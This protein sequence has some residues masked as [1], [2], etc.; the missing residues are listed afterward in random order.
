MDGQ[1]DPYGSTTIHGIVAKVIMGSHYNPFKKVD[2]TLEQTFFFLLVG[3]YDGGKLSH[4]DG[5][6]QAHNLKLLEDK[7]VD[8]IHV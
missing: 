1:I 7:I 5:R 4:V 8:V 2:L 6:I 3:T